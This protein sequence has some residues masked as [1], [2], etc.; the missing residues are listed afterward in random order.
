MPILLLPG[1]AIGPETGDA[2]TDVPERALSRTPAAA[3][4]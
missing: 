2:G 1:G 3:R 4:G